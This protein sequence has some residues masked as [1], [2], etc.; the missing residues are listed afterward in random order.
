MTPSRPL[1]APV[2]SHPASPTL[3]SNTV[4]PGW[5]LKKRKPTEALG[6]CG[7]PSGVSQP[8]ITRTVP[9]ARTDRVA[10]VPRRPQHSG[11]HTDAKLAA[12]IGGNYVP[13]RTGGHEAVH[14]VDQDPA[15]PRRS[16]GRAGVRGL[17][18]PE[19][20]SAVDEGHVPEE[21]PP[22]SDLVVGVPSPA[23]QGGTAPRGRQ[24]ADASS[25]PVPNPST[26]RFWY[27]GT[28]SRYRYRRY[29]VFL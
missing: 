26:L 21:L 1:S 16:L 3:P 13:E 27:P 22:G 12:I 8:A 24:H 25:P 9:E 10:T 2:A 15:A 5:K 14:G 28:T 18:A 23:I 6:L 4:R 7:P 17:A 11:L 29:Q 19:A 20:D